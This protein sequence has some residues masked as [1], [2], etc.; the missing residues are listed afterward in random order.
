MAFS[1][2]KREAELLDFIKARMA[3]TGIAPSFEEMRDA[4]GFASKS[5]VHALISRLEQ[6][7]HI[8]RIKAHARAIE[9]IDKGP[10][11]LRAALRALNEAAYAAAKLA[12]KTQHPAAEAIRRIALDS[13]RILDEAAP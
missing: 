6:R 12:G 10:V 3:E 1:M 13:D 4:L 5:G 7:G 2:T 11:D 8:R 9:I